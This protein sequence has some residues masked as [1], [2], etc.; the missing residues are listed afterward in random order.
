MLFH[1]FLFRKNILFHLPLDVQKP[2]NSDILS[3]ICTFN[4]G[5]QSDIYL[6]EL[7]RKHNIYI[8]YKFIKPQV[9]KK[10]IY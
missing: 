2:L 1:F 4:I 5:I 6:T 10:N 7:E 3:C 8:L 9:N